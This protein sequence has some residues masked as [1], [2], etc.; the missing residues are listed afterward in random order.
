MPEDSANYLRRIL[1]RNSSADR[2][3][4]ENIVSYPFHI[5][6]DCLRSYNDWNLRYSIEKSIGAWLP[7]AET[8]NVMKIIFPENYELKYS[9][10]DEFTSHYQGLQVSHNIFITSTCII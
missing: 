4:V 9:D 6:E 1:R 2:T 7:F 5:R 3:K 10:S 8:I